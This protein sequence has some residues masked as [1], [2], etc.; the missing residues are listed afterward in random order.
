MWYDNGGIDKR[1]DALM[2]DHY[3]DEPP[4]PN[5]EPKS[6]MD[7]VN[8]SKPNTI[9][10]TTDESATEESATEESTT[11]ESATEEGLKKI[12]FKAPL[13]FDNATN[14]VVNFN[15]GAEI[16]G[17]SPT[18]FNDNDKVLFNDDI[19]LNTNSGVYFDTENPRK[20]FK[21]SDLESIKQAIGKKKA[22]YSVL[23]DVSRFDKGEEQFTYSSVIS[24]VKDTCALNI[25]EILKNPHN[26]TDRDA[27][28]N[29]CCVND[30]PKYIHVSVLRLDNSDP[31]V[32]LQLH[33]NT[34]R[35]YQIATFEQTIGSNI[36]LVLK[37]DKVTVKCK[38]TLIKDLGSRYVRNFTSYNK[39]EINSAIKKI[40]DNNSNDIVSLSTEEPSD[41]FDWGIFRG[42][43]VVESTV[44]MSKFDSNRRNF[45]NWALLEYF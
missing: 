13:L 11:E 6:L 41:L 4:L 27:L 44:N 26:Q 31:L 36:K 35:N 10:S 22:L 1:N 37:R 39:N 23:N 28:C 18:I 45:Y 19:I 15:N 24:N 38:L 21:K 5:C 20:S 16:N 2:V 42:T 14:N 29:A 43:T 25:W 30:I 17:K 7:S 8:D 34:G 12:V 32:D 40:Y 33:E 3:K 9:Q